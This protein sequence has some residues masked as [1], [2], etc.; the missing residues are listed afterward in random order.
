[1]FTGT[2]ENIHDEK[3]RGALPGLSRCKA[4]GLKRRGCAG[5]LCNQV[6][7]DSAIVLR[8][9]ALSGFRQ[10]TCHKPGRALF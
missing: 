10:H 7:G 6:Y 3:C 9:G 8:R 1:M 2:K 5:R 4:V